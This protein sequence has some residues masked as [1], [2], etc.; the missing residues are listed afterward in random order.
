MKRI[1]VKI[2]TGNLVSSGNLDTTKTSDIARQ[3]AELMSRGIEVVL[4]SSGAIQA[5]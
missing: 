3:V 1:V 2:G 4:V 5:G